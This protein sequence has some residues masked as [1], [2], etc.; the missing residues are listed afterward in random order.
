MD[1]HTLSKQ[2]NP[3]DYT[4]FIRT[5]RKHYSL[6]FREAWIWFWEELYI[7]T[8]FISSK[9]KTIMHEQPIK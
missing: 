5:A 9:A 4:D 1:K 3:Q 6:R 7:F 8:R 2:K